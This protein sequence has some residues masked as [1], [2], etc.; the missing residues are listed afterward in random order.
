MKSTLVL[1]LASAVSGNVLNRQASVCNADNCL[2]GI[3]GTNPANLPPLSQRLLDCSAFLRTT[4][5]PSTV[6]QTVTTTATFWPYIINGR[7]VAV[8]TLTVPSYA[9]YCLRVADYSSACI[10]V[11]VTAFPVTLRTPTVTVT[12]VKTTYPGPPATSTPAT[13][14][15]TISS[16]SSSA[17]SSSSSPAPSFTSSTSTS[18]SSTSTPLPTSIYA[19]FPADS[20]TPCGIGCSGTCFA[21]VTGQ[22]YCKK[23]AACP[24]LQFC[25]TGAD[26]NSGNNASGICLV[27]GCGQVCAQVSALCRNVASAK[28]L[29]A[30]VPTQFEVE[31]TWLGKR[32]VEM[33]EDGPHVVD[34]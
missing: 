32:R 15:S 23:A 2:R 31:T 28:M 6:T 18:T 21:D 10:C 20:T 26:C 11:G 3:R 24:G 7:Q 9:S 19:C 25:G 5:T 4:I 13:N 27:N 34:E 29:F 22:G 1:L 17:P 12:S 8:P 30:R 14:T 33:W 16:S